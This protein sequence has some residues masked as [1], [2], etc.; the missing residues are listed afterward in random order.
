MSLSGHLQSKASP[1]RAWFEE[2]FAGTRP[3]VTA[4]NRAL[5]E[6]RDACEVLSPEGSDPSLVGTA[7][8][9]FLRCHLSPEALQQTVA[10]NAAN[11]LG[12]TGTNRAEELERQ[13][14][15]EVE[16][17]A[18]W[19]RNLRMSEWRE[20]ALACTIL[21]RFEQWYRAGPAVAA[22]IKDPLAQLKDEDGF[23][24]LGALVVN[25]AS[26]DDTAALGQIAVEDHCDFKDPNPLYLNPKFAQSIPIGGAD[27]DLIVG[28]ELWDW[29]ATRQT[30]V[31]GRF[32]LWQLIG[33]VLCDTENE[34]SIKRVGVSALRW[35]R[36][37][38][39]PID[40]LLAEL[41]GAE[42]APLPTLRAEFAEVVASV[43]RTR[44]EWSR[45]VRDLRV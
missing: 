5:R 25:E 37:V 22:Y 42:P 27:A 31:V 2:R 24:E 41:A 18:P 35:R 39:W 30:G 32:E 23:R 36:R 34:Y 3:V 20:L 33:Y 43:A 1:V 40:E 44:A 17:L 9:Y 29:K 10:R 45:L 14:A 4:A 19:K 6:G 12:F 38:S 7:V 8:D 28:Q 11:L 21:A 26:L 15:A 13:A 16:R